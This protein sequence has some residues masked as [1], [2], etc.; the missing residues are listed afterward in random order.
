MEI[1]HHGQGA[2]VAAPSS[3]VGWPTAEGCANGVAIA[4]E[5][6]GVVDA[7]ARKVGRRNASVNIVRAVGGPR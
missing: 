3:G 7:A 5:S 6:R 4:T 2:V 1:T